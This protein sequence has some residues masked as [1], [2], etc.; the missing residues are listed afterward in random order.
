[1]RWQLIESQ[2]TSDGKGVFGG[3]VSLAV[4]TAVITGLVYATLSARHNDSRIQFD[5]T[6]VMVASPAEHPAPPP[7]PALDFPMKGFQTVVAPVLMPAA[8]PQLD[9]QEHFDPRDYSGMGVEGG[10]ASGIAS[11]PDKV[12]TESLVD[13]VPL[14]LAAPAP[15]YPSLLRLAGT[16]GRVV[17]QAI[18]DTT[19]RAEAGSIKVVRSPHIG[20]DQPSR[21]WML[22]A[23]FRPARVHGRPVRVYVSLPIDFT[24]TASSRTG[25]R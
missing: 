7:Q 11:D 20:F 9:L 6:L 12:W 18:V 15:E 16:S 8:I 19:G 1:M 14:L 5:T 4:H 22:Q 13:E 21:R 3:F 17:L 24:I 10:T 23:L 25:T 2:R